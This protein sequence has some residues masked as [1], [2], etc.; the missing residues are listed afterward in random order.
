MCVCVCK[1]SELS[2]DLDSTEPLKGFCVFYIIYIYIMYDGGAGYLK[3]GK[4][5][6]VIAFVA[7]N[8]VR[9]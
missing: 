4:G 8:G 2:A 9:L 3:S 5:S 6:Q 7:A 1:Q